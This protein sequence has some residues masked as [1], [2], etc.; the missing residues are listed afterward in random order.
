MFKDLRYLLAQCKNHYKNYDF[1]SS[2]DNE[3]KIMGSLR[4][5]AYILLSRMYST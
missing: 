2:N 3:A 4:E 1:A 5:K